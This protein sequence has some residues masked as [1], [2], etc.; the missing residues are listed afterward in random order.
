[1]FQT[2]AGHSGRAGRDQDRSEVHKK[3]RADEALSERRAGWFDFVIYAAHF[4]LHNTVL[5]YSSCLR[6]TFVDIKLLVAV[7]SGRA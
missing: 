7:L 5:C 1:M 2:N 6:R 3:R 4:Y